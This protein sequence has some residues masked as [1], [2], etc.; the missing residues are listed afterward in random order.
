MLGKY[1]LYWYDDDCDISDEEDAEADI[2]AFEGTIEV[3]IS[4]I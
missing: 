1:R 2:I 4:V 3:L